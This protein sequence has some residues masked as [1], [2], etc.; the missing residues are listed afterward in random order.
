MVQNSQD[1]A[2]SQSSDPNPTNA[3]PD[4]TKS[5]TKGATEETKK[6]RRPRACSNE[7]DERGRETH[8]ESV[9]LCVPDDVGDDNDSKVGTVD[10]GKTDESVKT[11]NKEKK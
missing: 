9:C 5:D 2:P 4:G 6:G 3:V 11:I 7:K 10:E 8:R 1:S